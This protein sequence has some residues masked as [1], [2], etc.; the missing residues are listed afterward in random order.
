[1]LGRLV[2]RSLRELAGHRRAAGTGGMPVRLALRPAFL[3]GRE[4]LFEE[5][6]ARLGGEPGQSGPRLAA[7]CGMGGAG[8]TSVAVEYAHRHLAEV[9]VCW[10]F[11]AED[12]TLLAAGFAALAA[13]LGVP[14]TADGQDPVASVHGVLARSEAA[15]LLVF[16]NATSR[17]AV[18]AFIPP[19]GPGRVLVTN[20]GPG[21]AARPSPRRPGPQH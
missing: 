9:G 10:Q 7:L 18:E 21:L 11:P 13:Q 2:E 12:P 4:A 20:P 5:L 14:G 15:W 17:A 1:M 6:D 16:D 3:A 19:A 8:K